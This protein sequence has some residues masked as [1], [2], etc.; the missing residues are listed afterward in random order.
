MKSRQFVGVRIDDFVTRHV[1]RTLRRR[2]WREAIVPFTG[3]G[4]DEHVRVLGRLTLRPSK[5]K[6]HLACTP[7][8][9]C[10]G[11]A[12]A[13]SS[14]RRCR[15]VG[16]VRGRRAGQVTDAGGYIDERVHQ[17]QHAV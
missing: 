9:S 5:L 15:G 7:R 8:P 1:V 10:S 16:T 14:P 12:G 17:R 4:T 2:G 13:T 6:T 11:A 3:Y